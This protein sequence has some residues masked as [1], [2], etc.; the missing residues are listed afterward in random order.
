MK[1]LMIALSAAAAALFTFGDEAP[2]SAADFEANGYVVGEGFNAALADDGV[3]DTGDRFWFSTDNTGNVIS[4]HEGS[5]TA[6]V[7][8]YFKDDV[9][10]NKYLWLDTTAP[11]F[12]TVG[13]NT[14]SMDSFENVQIG[15][16]G[17]YLDTLVKFTAADSAFDKDLDAGDKI[18]IEYVEC[19]ADTDPDGVGYTNFVIRAGYISGERVVQTNYF[20]TVPE[21]GF[22]KEAWHRLTVRTLP[23]IDDGG[24]VGFIVYLD[25]VSLAYTGD[26]G[27]NFEAAG[28]AANFYTSSIHAVYPS[29]VNTGDEKNTITSAS[30]SG[31]GAID[32]VVFTSETPNFIK[33]GEFVPARI[34]LGTGI[35]SVTVTVGE[36]TIEPVDAT[37]SP[38]IYNLPAGT[39]SFTLAATADSA[40]GYTFA[41]IDGATYTAGV[42][43]WA[44]AAPTFTVLATRNNVSYIDDDD[45]TVSCVTL[46]EA[47]TNAKDGSTITL[48]YDYTVADFET[49]GQDQEELYEI[50]NELT[51]DLNGKTLNGGSSDDYA[52]FYVSGALTVI[53]SSS[54]KTG[55]I[56]YG[57]DAGI[58]YV[59][60]DV[61]IGAET[62]DNGPTI[63]GVLF[64]E[65]ASGY[66]VRGKILA[67][68]N[69]DGDDFAW[70]LGDGGDVVSKATLIG[71]YW[72]VAP[73]GE[74][75]PAQTFALTTTGGANATVTTSPADVSAL[76]EA[77]QVTITAT[78]GNGYT[79]DGVDLTGT[80]WAF[81]STAD[82]ISLTLTV[83][84]DTEI[85][86]PDAVEEQ[87]VPETWTVTIALSNHVTSV[88]YV[89]VDTPETTNTLTT[90]DSFTIEK[91][92]SFVL[93]GAVAESGWE[94]DLE[95][96]MATLS[97]ATVDPT[98]F[99]VTPTANA[100]ATVIAKEVVVPGGYPTYIPDDADAKAKYDAWKDLYGD[101]TGSAYEDAFLLNCAPVNV[102]TEKAAFKLN[103]TVAGDTV[104]VTG[105]DGKNYNGTVQLKGS[106]DLTTWTDVE[107]ASKSYKFFKAE[108]S[109]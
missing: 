52:M 73:E 8:D 102:E 80:D 106:N 47:F 42:V 99:F 76:T 17:I 82:A 39:T 107:S 90:T 16:K 61:F 101:D 11:L 36:A 84:A 9:S 29:V 59:E 45:N 75:P 86:V 64:D 2:Y 81:D 108:L 109:L 7:P 12:R 100:S 95:A 85:A 97:G 96:S 48:A 65:T 44:G 22:D 72:F 79:Y 83:S 56:V 50:N 49:F 55:K 70:D 105:P 35:A 38:L 4:N 58:F 68:A 60:G 89:F 66:V 98:Y 46:T 34:T 92:K 13:A 57:G 24:H 14:G 10:N 74:E 41:G 62:G 1:K 71:N 88:S 93:V 91:G 40:N 25:Q 78:A 104:T 69:S 103:I 94:I 27:D 28:V 31:T 26:A 37:A 67:S 15:S 87:V 63:D 6:P 43:T 3:S 21:G 54:A 51:L 30:F 19:D 18:A 5:V 23:S 53:D 33:E 77:T 20:V 32:D